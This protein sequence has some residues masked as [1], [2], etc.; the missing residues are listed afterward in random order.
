[1]VPTKSFSPGT[2]TKQT[3]MNVHTTTYCD[4]N[5]NFY[6]EKK[7]NFKLELLTKENQTK[8]NNNNRQKPK[9]SSIK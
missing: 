4:F 5:C 7:H 6:T 1:M 2:K 9:H 3:K 8:T